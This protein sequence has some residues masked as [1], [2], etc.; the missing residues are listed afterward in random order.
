MPGDAAGADRVDGGGGSLAAGVRFANDHIF[1]ESCALQRNQDI[2]VD[3]YVANCCPMQNSASVTP[4]TF[5][6]QSRGLDSRFAAFVL[7]DTMAWDWV[8]TIV[9]LFMLVGVG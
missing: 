9:A 1:A 3:A 6:L 5:N 4:C 2:V 8:I 7:S